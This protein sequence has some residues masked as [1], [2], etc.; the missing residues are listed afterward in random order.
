MKFAIIFETLLMLFHSAN[1]FKIGNGNEE[2]IWAF[3]GPSVTLNAKADDWFQTCTLIKDGHEICQV[4]LSTQIP[5]SPQI[6]CT[7]N[8]SHVKYIGSGRKYFCK[9]EVPNLQ[10]N[11]NNHQILHCNRTY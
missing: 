6:I 4:T 10:E 7:L 9:F 1:S 8:Y 2:Y 11:G 5:Y 3:G